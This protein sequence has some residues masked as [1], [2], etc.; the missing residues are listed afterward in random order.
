MRFRFLAPLLLLV[1]Q[2]VLAAAPNTTQVGNSLFQPIAANSLYLN[3]TSGVAVP[4]I[5]TLTACSTGQFYNYA[6]GTGFICSGLDTLTFGTHLT[7]TN[8][9]GSVPITIATDATS[10]DI[11]GT[12]VARDGSGN[13]SAGII[14][15][16]LTGHASLDMPITGGTFTGE[17]VT[18]A[19]A[20]GGAGFNLPQGAAPSAPANGDVWMTSSGIF[21]RANGVTVG[22]LGVTGTGTVTNVALTAPAMFTATGCGASSTTWSCALTYSGTAL[23]IAD[24]GTGQTSAANAF[25]ALSPLTTAGDIIYGGASGVGTRLAAGTSTQVLHGGTTPSW[26]AVALTGLA[27]QATNTIVGN[28]T[29]GTSAPTALAIG[30]CSGASNALTW[31]TN[32]GFGC[33]TISASGLTLPVTV[34]GTVNSGGIPYFSSTTAMTSSAAGA[35]NTPMLWGGAGTAPASVAISGSTAGRSELTSTGTTTAP[36]FQTPA[37]LASTAQTTPTSTSSTSAVMMGLG[38]AWKLTP[39]KS[40]IVV[41]NISGIL[42][43]GLNVSYTCTAELVYGTGTAP[44]NGAAASG[45]AIGGLAQISATVTAVAINP[46]S[47]TAVIS[48]LTVGTAVWFDVQLKSS[49]GGTDTCV[50]TDVSENA[51]EQ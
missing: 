5:F 3:S 44:A 46:Y 47:Q 27:T 23:P 24:G 10:A 45:T 7:G 9:N 19:S 50:L 42:N 6:L 14:T 29:S 48:G 35:A 2:P 22:P 8:F 15:A 51:V 49:G 12:I 43:T 11:V 38:S 40:G 4:S 34:A 36:T 20:T 37:I 21:V 28:A 26:G 32:T 33:N 41:I 31:T 25:N 13:F 16:S 30:S 17:V 1:A 39:L 18:L